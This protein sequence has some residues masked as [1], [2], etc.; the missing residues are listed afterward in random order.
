MIEVVQVTTWLDDGIQ[1]DIMQTECWFTALTFVKNAAQ[2]DLK[3]E[4]TSWEINQ[5]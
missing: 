2:S 3:V 1:Q 4:V 5:K